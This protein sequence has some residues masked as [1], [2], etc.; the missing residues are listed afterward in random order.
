M[1]RW[2]WNLSLLDSSPLLF[3]GHLSSAHNLPC[4][5]F[6]PHYF[7]ALFV[8]DPFRSTSSLL[9]LLLLLYTAPFLILFCPYL[10]YFMNFYI[11]II[12]FLFLFVLFHSFRSLHPNYCCFLVLLLMALVFGFPSIQQNCF[13]TSSA[14]SSVLKMEP[15][16]YFVMLYHKTK[17]WHIVEYS[18]CLSCNHKVNNVSKTLCLWYLKKTASPSQNTYCIILTKSIW[19]VLCKSVTVHHSD[20]HTVSIDN[21]VKE[22]QS[23][24]FQATWAYE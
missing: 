10:F 3:L 13:F 4:W 7:N 23:L 15:G 17:W 22:M 6:L 1:T 21:S 24:Y 19:L 16:Y 12:H 14:Y 8:M 20:N 9:V 2:I 5:G 11:I 18:S